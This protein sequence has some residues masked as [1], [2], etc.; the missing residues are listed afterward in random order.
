M[1]IEKDKINVSLGIRAENFTFEMFR[2]MCIMAGCDYHPSL[3]GIGN[4]ILK[5][6]LLTKITDMNCSTS[7]TNSAFYERMGQK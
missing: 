6:L 7:I 3:P 4:S 5:K 2:Y 1:Q